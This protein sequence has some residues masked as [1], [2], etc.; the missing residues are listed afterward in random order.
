MFTI[1]WWLLDFLIF[2]MGTALDII[3][4][5]CNKIKKQ[6][7]NYVM[8]YVKKVHFGYPTTN[9][10]A[11]LNLPCIS[12]ATATEHAPCAITV[13]VIISLKIFWF[14]RYMKWVF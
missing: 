3:T 2:F 12:G 13:R 6:H 11:C 7:K 5:T 14:E 1:R 10:H 9:V 4:C 8:G